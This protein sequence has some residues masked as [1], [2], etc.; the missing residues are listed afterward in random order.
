[1]ALTCHSNQN[2][3]VSESLH[4]ACSLGDL[5]AVSEEIQDIEMTL[6]PEGLE[7][8]LE[9]EYGRSY[10]SQAVLGGHEEI[11]K[12]L[13]E[14]GADVSSQDNSGGS[15]LHVAAFHGQTGCAR[16]LLAAG[17][18]V[19]A[20]DAFGDTPLHE[21]C[22]QGNLE[23]SKLLLEAGA[24][25]FAK[26]KDGDT[27]LHRA[28]DAENLDL[29]LELTV[30]DPLTAVATNNDG[31]LPLHMAVEAGFVE[32]AIGLVDAGANVLS[33]DSAGM[34]VLD[35]IDEQII[36]NGEVFY[37]MSSYI[38]ASVRCGPCVD[39]GAT[40]P[41]TFKEFIRRRSCE[42]QRWQR[43]KHLVTMMS[44]LGLCE[45]AHNSYSIKTGKQLQ[46]QRSPAEDM[47]RLVGRHI[48]QF[49]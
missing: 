3:F 19:N 21:S 34:S 7:G 31:Q 24:D 48:A 28:C 49:L 35:T 36:E 20:L 14:H 13:L 32:G 8:R 18:N 17:A 38:D 23:M 41:M 9:V 46:L 6:V 2:H 22:S 43:R 26:D 29:V 47:F 39:D 15:A 37:P 44:G 40:S 10:L 11:V 25:I 27:P 4:R 45:I 5:A 1:M 16:L 12:M 42:K 30:R 33:Q